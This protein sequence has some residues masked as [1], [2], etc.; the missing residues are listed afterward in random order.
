MLGFA[1]RLT[2]EIKAEVSLME[3]TDRGEEIVSIVGKKHVSGCSLT[4]W[5]VKRTE[6]M[7]M[8]GEDR[9][10]GALRLEKEIKAPAKN[11]RG[12]SRVKKKR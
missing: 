2:E 6:H 1:L 4:L 11:T 8:K 12:G 5:I 3:E 10:S 9:S 7:K